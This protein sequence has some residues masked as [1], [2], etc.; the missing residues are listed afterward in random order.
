MSR[1]R[2]ISVAL[3][4]SLAAFLVP[5][6][7]NAVTTTT[8]YVQTS[9]DCSTDAKCGINSNNTITVT[10][11]TTT[12]LTTISASLASGW[13]FVDTGANGGGGSLNF[14]FTSSQP[15]I[16]LT[17]TSSN[18]WTTT[19][20]Q[21]QVQGGTTGSTATTVSSA[22]IQAPAATGSTFSFTNGFAI[23]CNTNGGS[24]SCS[25][26]L[27]FTLNTL[28]ALATSGGSTFFADVLSSN[29]NTGIIDFTLSQ[30]PLP[31]AALLFG[32]GLIGLTAL[33]RRRAKSAP[34]MA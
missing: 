10:A 29:G 25:S 28:A 7:A 23:T 17:N 22:L 13:S 32:S 19:N 33:R 2:P 12:G 3:G 24:T 15:S 14:G 1:C 5:A 21:F 9:D 27:T 30:V 6:A 18:G 4:L 34:V 16:T 8:T 31:P 26:P 20:G 11:N